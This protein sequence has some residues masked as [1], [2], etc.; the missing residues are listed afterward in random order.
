MI[1]LSLLLPFIGTSLGAAMVFFLKGEINAKVQ[2]VLLGFASGVMVAASIWSLILPAM[3]MV[4]DDLGKWSFMPAAIGFL[5]GMFVLLA[6][7]E[8]IPHLHINSDKPEGL[9]AKL[10]RSTMLILAV[11]IH[12][13]PEGAATGAVIAGFLSGNET[14][15][16]A[17]VL[18]LSLGIAIQNVPEGAIISMPLLAEGKKKGGSFFIGSMTGIVEP[19]AAVFMILLASLINPILPYMLSFAAGAMMYV[20]VEELIP[21]ASQGDHSNFATIAFALGFTLMMI[22]DVFLG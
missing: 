10:K 9:K 7:D 15:T 21:E 2:K 11:T 19:I 17:S 12:N 3:D 22:L 6:L 8:L 1:A 13:V 4:G 20:V 16:I 18:S 14:L 5:M